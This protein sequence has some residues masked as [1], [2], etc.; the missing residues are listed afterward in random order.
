[1]TVHIKGEWV[2]DHHTV[3]MDTKA[4]LIKEGRTHTVVCIDIKGE[5][6][7]IMAVPNDSIIDRY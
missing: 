5:D 1:M 7:I 6:S 4:T 3:R 2:Q